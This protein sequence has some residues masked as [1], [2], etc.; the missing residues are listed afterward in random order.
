MKPLNPYSRLLISVF[1]GKK[2][3]R[4]EFFFLHENLVSK[5]D[6]DYD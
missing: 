5:N 3:Q 2:G 1:K 6:I 4:S